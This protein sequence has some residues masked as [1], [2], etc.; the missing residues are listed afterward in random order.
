MRLALLCGLIVIHFWYSNICW[1]SKLFNFHLKIVTQKNGH[2][3]E[4]NVQSD[5]VGFKASFVF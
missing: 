5:I 3:A 2:F 4:I 1:H